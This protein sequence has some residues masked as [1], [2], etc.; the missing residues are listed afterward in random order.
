MG[1]SP[2]LGATPNGPSQGRA[3][4]DIELSPP[5]HK[6]K[7]ITCVKYVRRSQY[8]SD[9]LLQYDQ[10]RMGHEGRLWA[11]PVVYLSNRAEYHKSNMIAEI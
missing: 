4:G 1:R 11:R 7:P 10:C 2:E 5:S 3:R 9:K 6:A 8:R